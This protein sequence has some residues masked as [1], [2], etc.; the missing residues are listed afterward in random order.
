[1]APDHVADETIAAGDC[2]LAWLPRPSIDGH[3]EAPASS[4][5]PRAAGAFG[6]GARIDSRLER[7]A[8]L[9]LGL[10]NEEEAAQC[11]P[12]FLRTLVP[13][14][15]GRYLGAPGG[16]GVPVPLRALPPL[17]LPKMSHRPLLSSEDKLS[18]ASSTDRRGSPP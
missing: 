12:Q 3:V 16:W 14:E 11:G 9:S 4:R 17:T 15:A 2:H 18:A 10:A 1:M 5:S 8:P 13:R 6:V 7:V